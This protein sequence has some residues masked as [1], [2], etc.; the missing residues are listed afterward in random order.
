MTTYPYGYG[1]DRGS[2]DELKARYAG[3]MHP[4]YADCVFAWI[5]SR[6]GRV[7]IGSAWRATQPSLP[8]F[9]PEGMSFHQD[10]LFASGF[11]G[12]A[13]VDLVHED[14]GNKHRMIRWDEVPAQGTADAAFW[15]VHCNVSQESWHM[16]SINADGWVRWVSDG[17]PDPIGRT[18]APP[19]PPDPVFDPKHCKFAGWPKAEHKALKN[20]GDTG[21]AI[22]YAQGV[23]RFIAPSFC[24]WFAAVAMKNAEQFDRDDMPGKARYCRRIAAK[25]R[26][27]RS[28]C[29]QVDVD[30]DFG[31]KTG[32]AVS[33][34][35]AA[36]HGRPFQGRRIDFP[37]TH[38]AIGDEMWRWIDGVSDKRW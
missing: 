22:S 36:F 35:K 28:C 4:N 38:P 31:P 15:K 17:R 13:A 16:Q 25:L 12:C 11:V 23:I 6:G 3:E 21:D 14:P 5:E 26:A 34:L 20:E 32:I 19:K 9:A 30:G 8:G 1:T 24:K 10:Q 18:P 29:L 27:A 2:L 37:D 7:G 33:A